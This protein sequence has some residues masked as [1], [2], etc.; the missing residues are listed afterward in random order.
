MEKTLSSPQLKY[1]PLTWLFFIGYMLLLLFFNKID[2]Y[3][4]HFFSTGF[5]IFAYNIF[6]V[7]FMLCLMWLCYLIGDYVLSL[8]TK[9]IQQREIN[10]ES[11]LLAFFTGLSIWHIVLLGIGFA[12]WYT[13]IFMSV[14]TLVLFALSLPRLNQWIRFLQTHRSSLYWP[15]L[16]LFLIPTFFFLVTKGLYPAGG[17][18]YFTHYFSYYR[19]VTESGSIWPGRLWYHFYYDKGMGLFFLSMLLTDPLAPQLVTTTMIF[20]SAGVVFSLIRQ[21]TSWRLLPW[22]AIALYITFLIY[23][24]GSP[25]ARLETGWGDLEKS[26]EPATILMFSILWITI[27]LAQTS[28]WKTWR[29]ALILNA[30]A[31]AI[32]SLAMAVFAG[33]YLAITFLCFVVYKKKTAA[34]SVFWGLVAISLWLAFSLLINY[35][36][37]GLPDEQTVLFWWPIINFDKVN[38]WGG[39]I[40]V[41]NLCSGRIAGSASK[42]PITFD[43]IKKIITYLRL[44]IWGPLLFMAVMSSF[45]TLNKQRSKLIPI[46]QAKPSLFACGGFLLLIFCLSL[47]IGR[48]QPV[49]FYRFTS[50]TYAPTLCFCLLLISTFLS[51][52]KKWASFI[53][54]LGF[55]SA[56][57]VIGDHGFSFHH[58]YIIIC[59]L[60]LLS[61]LYAFSFYHAKIQTY[62]FPVLGIFFIWMALDHFS[63]E[64]NNLFRMIKNGKRFVIGK[65]SIAHAYRDQEGWPGRMPWGGIYPPLET[66]WHQLPPKT[67]IWSW[68]IHSYCMLPDCDIEGATSF[69]MSSHEEV[70]FFGD[71]QKAKEQL[72]KDH[73]NY[74]FFSNQLDTRDPLILAPLFSAKHIA[75]YLGIVWTN[76]EDT[77]LTWKEQARIPI[78]KKWLTLYEKNNGN[79]EHQMRYNDIKKIFDFTD[80]QARNQYLRLIKSRLVKAE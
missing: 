77:L 42:V 64:N 44:D 79:A 75:D 61:L 69:K 5:L 74:F 29:I 1:S 59:F 27:G 13:R 16:L 32:M 19:E 52:H 73:L 45:F 33:V 3:H 70:I 41:F 26:H 55:L 12:G 65:Y 22:I 38:E 40:Q 60:L 39:L 56:Y 28:Q 36:I 2:V 9:N 31:L 76:G 4:D 47:F 30:S 66:I 78:D 11:A 62:F 37:T 57:L 46:Q 35:L 51:D 63:L 6:R 43:Y 15:G 7:F 17:H 49:S 20:A 80:T 18:D 34:I 24:P 8:L 72:K 50:F 14:M 25:E 10:L 53:L 58:R 67:R 68:H 48:D 71:P 21:T 54:I 23:T